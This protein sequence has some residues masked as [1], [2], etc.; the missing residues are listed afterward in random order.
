M[1]ER[2]IK[3]KVT[4]SACLNLNGENC[5]VL[6]QCENVRHYPRLYSEC[7]A[8]PVTSNPEIKRF[9]QHY[10]VMP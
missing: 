1:V 4:C 10:E 8:K 6:E 7:G 9:C 3:Q 5:N 2:E